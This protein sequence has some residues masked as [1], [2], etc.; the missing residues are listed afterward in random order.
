VSSHVGGRSQ[1]DIGGRIRL[2]AAGLGQQQQ[3]GRQAEQHDKDGRIAKAMQNAILPMQAASASTVL[4]G[5]T[6]PAPAIVQGVASRPAGAERTS[7]RA[8][9]DGCSKVW[10]GLPCTRYET[11]STYNMGLGPRPMLAG[12]GRPGHWGGR[13][14]TAGGRRVADGV[15]AGLGAGLGAEGIGDGSPRSISKAQ[16]AAAN[17]DARRAFR[18]RWTGSMG[19]RGGSERRE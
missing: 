2:R 9:C 10:R 11:T 7:G 12:G 18:R 5:A 1:T 3:A 13:R 6:I 15:G 4:L 19:E 14:S 16:H 17:S 8:W